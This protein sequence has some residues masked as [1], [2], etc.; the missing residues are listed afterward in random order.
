L[1]QSKYVERVL[2]RFQHDNCNVDAIPID[3][4]SSSDLSIH[5]GDTISY[6]FKE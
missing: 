1:D 5:M 2:K 3:L 6:P 4:N